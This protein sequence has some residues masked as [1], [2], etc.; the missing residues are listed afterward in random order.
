MRRGW[1]Y[2]VL[3]VLAALVPLFLESPFWIGNLV[4]AWIF[5]LVA[6]SLRPLM[7]MHL[8]NSAPAALMG[9]GAYA[10]ALAATKFGLSVWLGLLGAVTAS[11]LVA[12]LTGLPVLRVRG[13]YFI[14]MTFAFN[15]VLRL[16][17]TNVD[18]LGGAAGISR[19]P[20]LSLGPWALTSRIHYYYFSLFFLALGVFLLMRLDRSRLGKAWKAIRENEPLAEAVG[21]NLMKYKLMAYIIGAMMAGAGGWLFAHYYQY[22]SPLNFTIWDSIALLIAIQFG[23]IVQ[24]FGPVFGGFFLVLLPELLRIYLAQSLPF[25][26]KAEARQV[27]FGAA[28]VVAI[29]FFPGGAVDLVSKGAA[30]LGRAFRPGVTK[31]SKG[32]TAGVGSRGT[33]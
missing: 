19:I 12:L 30:R 6:L 8:I 5:I 31:E 13:V 29:L 17:I 16:I 18:Y 26:Q 7:Y 28:I 14:V 2:L 10:A 1:V 25:F 23:G 22:I 9:V 27:V 33:P 21:I 11:G 20:R 15:E 3:L 4:W 32:T 24:L